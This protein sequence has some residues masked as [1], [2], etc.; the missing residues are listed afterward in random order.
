MEITKGKRGGARPGSGRPKGVRDKATGEQR[1]SLEE[2]A[3]THTELALGV[4]VK[5]AQEGESESARVGAANSILD[6]G[7]GRPRQAMDVTA[8]VKVEKIDAGYDEFA[9]ILGEAARDKQSGAD[10]AENLDTEGPT[11][12]ANT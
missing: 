5:V 7:Y 2:L 4:L 8:D 6:R 9:G 3:R 10:S 11:E 1:A 12:P